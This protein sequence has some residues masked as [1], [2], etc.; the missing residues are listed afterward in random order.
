MQGWPVAAAPEAL[1]AQ[2]RR[3]IAQ[4]AEA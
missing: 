4:G 3:A 1:E 2:R